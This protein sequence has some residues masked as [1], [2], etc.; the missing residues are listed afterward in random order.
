MIDDGQSD[1]TILDHE[2][3]ITVPGR[4]FEKPSNEFLLLLE[5]R[6]GLEFINSLVEQHEK[7][8]G[9][10][11]MTRKD[12][13]SKDVHGPVLRSFITTKI[14]IEVPRG[15]LT[16][17]F[18]WYSISACQYVRT[19]GMIAY[20]RD[21]DQRKPDEYVEDVIP[22]VKSFRDK[23]GA[24]TAWSVNSRR[25]NEAERLASVLPQ[26]AI[27][28]NTFVAGIRGIILTRGG[29]R[30]DSH[31]IKPWSITRVHKA[32]RERYWPAPI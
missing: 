28:D 24:H 21:Q 29:K 23:I 25:D 11:R 19:I 15:L 8:L 27:H 30:T 10:S 6:D 18:H 12:S 13:E 9:T 31:S 26:L 14:P 2:D 1:F 16:C 3:R 17:L 22:T 20:R 4:P 5:L 32:L 7:R